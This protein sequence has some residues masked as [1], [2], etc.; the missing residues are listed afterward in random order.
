MPAE[1]SV[2]QRFIRATGQL[3]PLSDGPGEQADPVVFS[4]PDGGYAMGIISTEPAPERAHGPGYGRFRFEAEKV[5]KWNCV[6][7]VRD[8]VAPGPY[9]FRMFVPMGTREDVVKA[10][11][12]LSGRTESVPATP[13]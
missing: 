12:T 13:K 5:V 11:R 7:R 8:G 3:E 9:R 1:F 10:M 4:T 2:F 6:F